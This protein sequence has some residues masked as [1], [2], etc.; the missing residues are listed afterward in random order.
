[1]TIYRLYL[2]QVLFGGIILL[3]SSCNNGQT[4]KEFKQKPIQIRVDEKINI[5]KSDTII[6]SKK[7]HFKDIICNLD[8]DK[9]LDSVK[10]VQNTI[11]KKYGLK[12]SYGNKRIDYL[13]MGKE[14]IHQ[15]FD[16]LEWIGVFEKVNKGDTIWS[17]VDGGEIIADD[18]QIKDEDKVILQNDGIFIHQL[19][20][21]G[22]GIIYRDGKYY[23]WVQQE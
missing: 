4:P 11:N 20:S 21:C 2:K 13:G 12:I 19:E 1:M 22:G 9:L 5:T 15:G 10:I 17:N 8:G 16:D 18:S 23:K 3:I 6:K 7:H 14:V